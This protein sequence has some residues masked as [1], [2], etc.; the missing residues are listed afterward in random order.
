MTRLAEILLERPPHPFWTVLRQLGIRHAVGVLP[1]Y[2]ADWREHAGELP[3]DYVP[4]ALYR[5]EVA[6]AGLRLVAIEDN[7]PMDKLRLGAPGRE[8]ELEAVCTLIRNMGRLGIPVWCYNWMTVL[9]WLRTSLAVRGRGGA[10]VSAYDHRRMAAA[11]LTSAGTVEAEHLWET[12]G[13][14]LERVCP[15][16]EEAGVTL[17]MHPD[18]PPIAS[19]RGIARIMSSVDAFERLVELNPSPANAITLCQGN[20]AL[21]TDDLPGTIRRLGPRIAFAHF[22]DVRG[23]P[24]HFEETFH[25]DGPTDMLACMRAYR[26]AGFTGVLRSDHV[27]TIEG[28]QADVA[29]YSHHARLHA[30]G[31][32]TGLREAVERESAAQSVD[33]ARPPAVTS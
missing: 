9:G 15:V 25:D 26:D 11:P 2:F 14:F 18:D 10:L 5:D 19:I 17:A 1:R 21:M 30:I 31:Y 28:D 4:L 23:T 13:W 16:A 20:F 24:E 8:E 12:L 29:G 33:G 6:D 7:P 3:W 27:P 22:R 32:M